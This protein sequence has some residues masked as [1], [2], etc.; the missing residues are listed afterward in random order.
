MEPKWRRGHGAVGPGAKTSWWLLTAPAALPLGSPA[1]RHRPAAE[2]RAQRPPSAGRPGGPRSEPSRRWFTG[3]GWNGGP[4]LEAVRGAQKRTSGRAPPFST[5]RKRPGEGARHSP[6]LA[7]RMKQRKQAPGVPD[8]HGG[9]FPEGPSACAGRPRAGTS[10]TFSWKPATLPPRP[11]TREAPT[12]LVSQTSPHPCGSQGFT[13][14]PPNISSPRPALAGLPFP[15]TRPARSRRRRAGPGSLRPRPPA[16]PP[17]AHPREA[18]SGVR[19]GSLG[20][21]LK[22]PLPERRTCGTMSIRFL[23]PSPTGPRPRA[24]RAGD[25]KPRGRRPAPP[26]PR[27]PGAPP[28][29]PAR[30]PGSA[31]ERR[32]WSAASSEARGPRGGC[33]SGHGP[34]PG[35]RPAVPR[36]ERPAVPC[37]WPCPR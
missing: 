18:R 35:E 6:A 21:P 1:W 4:I 10:A 8:A 30:R 36:G 12:V 14:K 23:R 37:R 20:T 29:A 32:R 3:R 5:C 19:L 17:G 9:P 11:R 25:R 33:S 24:P 28:G 7:S 16:A 27:G 31:L 22:A 2:P 26:D 13:R 15:G 34:A